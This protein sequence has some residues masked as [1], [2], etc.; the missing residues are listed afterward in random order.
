MTIIDLKTMRE[1]SSPPASVV[2]IGNFDGVHIGHTALAEETIAKKLQLSNRYEGLASAAC[3]FK[4]PPTDFF[5]HP[6]IPRLTTF[7]EKLSLF[8]ALGLDY[9][10]VIDFE[11]V[12]SLSAEAFVNAILKETFHCVFAVCGFNF[13]FGKNASGDAAHLKS[14][15]NGQASVIASVQAD[16]STVSSSEIRGMISRGE[17]EKI[18][19]FL[20]RPYAI[21]AEVLHGK[22]LGRTLGTPTINQCFPENLAI[23]KR[24]IYVTRSVI[25][26]KTFPSVTNVGL[27]PSV[28]DGDKINCETHILDFQGDL[29]EKT[30]TVQFL[31]YLR[32]EI[33]FENT[34]ALSAQ[35]QKDIQNTKAYYEE[36]QNL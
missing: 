10:F 26:G 32:G 17:M 12:G 36:A 3:F 24:G 11:E 15:M 34:E 20:G 30:V 9:A 23:P 7:E 25:N 4:I 18:P 27:R 16:G 31:K 1:A 28:N 19:A 13:H 6:P 14:L 2:C 22:A 33:K 21:T 35:I 5:R 8:S 29:Y